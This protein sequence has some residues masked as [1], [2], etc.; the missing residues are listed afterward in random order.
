MYNKN[1][2]NQAF[3][4]ND[5]NAVW[6]KGKIIPGYDPNIWRRDT[7]N[8]NIK[9]SEYGNVSSVN[10]WEIDHIKPKSLGGSDELSNLQP[11]QWE[12]NRHKGDNF[13]NWSC[14]IGNK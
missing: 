13:P 3:T 7:C 9:R 11:L 8:V 6:N 10:G 2:R 4:E 5:I 1:I 12:N 14:K